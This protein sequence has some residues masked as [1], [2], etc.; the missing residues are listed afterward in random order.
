MDEVVNPAVTDE[1]VNAVDEVVVTDEVI[2]VDDTKKTA[3]SKK[4]VE[5]EPEAE[6]HNE[7]VAAQQ[8]AVSF[9]PVMKEP[10]YGTKVAISS[11]SKR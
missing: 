1:E 11:R 9:I 2:A 3:K 4:A 10:T 5:V 8:E 7:V 6:P